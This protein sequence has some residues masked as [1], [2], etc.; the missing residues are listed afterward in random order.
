MA[1]VASNTRVAALDVNAFSGASRT[2]TEISENFENEEPILALPLLEKGTI[3]EAKVY[4]FIAD[5]AD[6]IREAINASVITPY[7]QVFIRVT[8]I[9]AETGSADDAVAKLSEENSEK[10]MFLDD[11]GNEITNALGLLNATNINVAAYLE[12]DT[13]YSLVVTAA[14]ENDSVLGPSGAGCI[15]GSAIGLIAMMLSSGIFRIRRKRK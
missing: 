2:V 5:I 14:E 8:K 6:K 4:V 3:T 11:E 9:S 15:T 10:G 1:G 13:D 12:P 7:S